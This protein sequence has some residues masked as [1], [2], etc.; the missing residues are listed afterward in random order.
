MHGGSD[1]VPAPGA[2]ASQL[3]STARG[4]PGGAPVSRWHMMACQVAAPISLDLLLDLP[5]GPR[6]WDHH[7]L[8]VDSKPGHGSL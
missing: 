2:A 1:A 7:A 5:M 3:K 8:R 4:P 6:S